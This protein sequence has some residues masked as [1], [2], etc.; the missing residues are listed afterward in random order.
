MTRSYRDPSPA[1][2]TLQLAAVLTI[3]LVTAP[4]LGALK[5]AYAD[6][7]EPA[8]VVSHQVDGNLATTPDAS[9][10]QWAQA[11]HGHADSLDGVE[12]GIM[13]V[14]NGTYIVFLI[15][16]SFNKSIGMA[17]VG[18]SFNLTA[19]DSGNAVWG[20]VGGQNNSTDAE[21]SSAGDLTGEELTAVFGRPI[22]PALN[23]EVRFGVGQ[24][25]EDAVKVTSWNN[26]TAP[27]SLNYEE[28]PAMGLELLPQIDLFPKAPLI[29]GAVILVATLGF[30][31]MEARRYRD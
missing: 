24:L 14:H 20:W 13:S 23:S 17:A 10:S 7:E 3:L 30:V 21:V 5:M 1:E 9:L 19:F 29:Y 16:R 2:R 22:V 28:I 18:I 11:H 12:M 27:T 25:Y 6:E 26:G 15:E 4:F 31:L 8:W